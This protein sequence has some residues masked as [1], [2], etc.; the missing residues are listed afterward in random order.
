MLVV[1]SSARTVGQRL[2]RPRGG[3]FDHLRNPLN[4]PVNP[5]CRQANQRSIFLLNGTGPL[6]VIS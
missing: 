1:P 2:P 3:L 6:A 4:H 5:H